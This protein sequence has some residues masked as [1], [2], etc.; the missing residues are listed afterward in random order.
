MTSESKLCTDD[1]EKLPTHDVEIP[2]EWNAPSVHKHRLFIFHPRK[3]DLQRNPPRVD[4]KCAS[5]KQKLVV[6]PV[7]TVQFTFG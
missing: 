2:F 1:V 4:E 7:S 6:P 5:C 3:F